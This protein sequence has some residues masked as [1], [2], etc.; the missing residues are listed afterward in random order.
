MHDNLPTCKNCKK[1]SSN[2]HESWSKS[3]II[4]TAVS[5]SNVRWSWFCLKEKVTEEDYG[6]FFSSY[7]GYNK[8]NSNSTCWWVKYWISFVY[9]IYKYF[10]Q[11]YLIIDS[12]ITTYNTVEL[13]E[14][15]HRVPGIMLLA[16][17]D[18]HP[19]TK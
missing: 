13:V 12:I 8:C 7:P 17:F 16:P 6:S 5:K 4:V 15:T 11:L 19:H 14:K 3:W 18:D 1:S 2:D 10:P 9:N